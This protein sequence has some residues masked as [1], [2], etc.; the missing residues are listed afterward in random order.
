MKLSEDEKNY[1][2]YSGEVSNS[3]YAPS[4]PRVRI[5][6][7]KGDLKEITEVSDMLNHEALSG[8]I[9]KYYLCYPKEVR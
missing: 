5:F 9:T 2:V 3:T 7:K 8:E 4:A 6:T 1:Y